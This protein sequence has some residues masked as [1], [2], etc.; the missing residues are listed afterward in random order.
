LRS[1]RATTALFGRC[2]DGAK[3]AGHVSFF[4]GRLFVPHCHEVVRR[5]SKNENKNARMGNGGKTAKENKMY[6]TISICL[7]R[8]ETNIKCN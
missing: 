1:D 3:R 7:M 2:L 8:S 4:F 5:G 6:P